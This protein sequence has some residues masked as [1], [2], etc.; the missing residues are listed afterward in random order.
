MS[1]ND[2]PPLIQIDQAS[3]E[4]DV[5]SSDQNAV[6]AT[7]TPP[8]PTSTPT[9]PLQIPH[10]IPFSIILQR[11]TALIPQPS[12]QLAIPNSPSTASR[13][14]SHPPNTTEASDASSQTSIDNDDARTNIGSKE[15]IEGDVSHK[16]LQEFHLRETRGSSV[17]IDYY[18]ASKSLPQ[19]S[20]DSIEAP[21]RNRSDTGK[22]CYC[23]SN[24]LRRLLTTVTDSIA[25]KSS[26][27]SPT[28]SIKRTTGYSP[29]VS[30]SSSYEENQKRIR[31]SNEQCGTM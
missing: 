27:E 11:T 25:S 30:P 2:P 14:S 10:D 22:C 15:D 16:D 29:S 5:E 9:N 21:R 13:I 6:A 17:D 26:D 19:E 28:G 12:S 1:R 18:E 24:H 20:S 3:E 4:E 7:D 23:N 8:E 31:E